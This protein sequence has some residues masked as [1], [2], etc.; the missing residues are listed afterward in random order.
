MRLEPPSPTGRCFA[1]THKMGQKSAESPQ[2][3]VTVTSWHVECGIA[4]PR[5]IV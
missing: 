4:P 3:C 5:V 2:L 1:N